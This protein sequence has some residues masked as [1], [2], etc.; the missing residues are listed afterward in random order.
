MDS[1]SRDWLSVVFGA[2]LEQELSAGDTGERSG[3]GEIRVRHTPARLVPTDEPGRELRVRVTVAPPEP[4]TGWVLELQAADPDALQDSARIWWRVVPGTWQ[5]MMSSPQ[6]LATGRD[7]DRL[8]VDL[9]AA[10]EDV[11]LPSPDLR[12]AARPR[13]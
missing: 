13:D 10:S 4:G 9:R 3:P 12:F 11:E 6:E 8:D 1:R 5:P 7:R 2:G